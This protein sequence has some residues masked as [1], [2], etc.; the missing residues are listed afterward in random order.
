MSVDMLFK[1]RI[2]FDLQSEEQFPAVAST[3]E[4]GRYQ[5]GCGSLPKPSWPCDTNKAVLCIKDRE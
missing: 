3:R 5:I 1:V 4:K 2:V